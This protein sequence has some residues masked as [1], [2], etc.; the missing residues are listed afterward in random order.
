MVRIHS[1]FVIP[2]WF[3]WLT[4]LIKVP[5]WYIEPAEVQA[6]RV[7]GS[8]VAFSKVCDGNLSVISVSLIKG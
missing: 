5:E 6:K 1:E 8:L 4:N 2:A 7:E 3:G